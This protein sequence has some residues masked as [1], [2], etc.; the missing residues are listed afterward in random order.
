[1]NWEI[2]HMFFF[3]L[4]L[5]AYMIQNYSNKTFSLKFGGKLAPIQNEL[6]VIGAALVLLVAGYA[7]AMPSIA[8]LY[9][10]IYGVFY[11]L[12][13]FFL[14]LAV[15]DGSLG[16]S[17]IICNMG[18]IF[19]AVFG[20]LFYADPFG[21]FTVIGSICM[22]LAVILSAPPSDK[23][24]S[25][26]RAWFFFALLSACSNGTLG[27][28]K[29]HVT[30]TMPELHS[31]TFLFWSFLFASAVGMLIIAVGI[32]R[33]LPIKECTARFGTKLITGLGAGLGTALAN[34]FFFLA[35]A[36]NI[37]S[38]ILFPLNTGLLSTLLFL[39]SWLVFK[40]TKL[41]KR[42]LAALVICVLGAIFINIK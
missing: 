6:C 34:L 9:A 28:L 30:R 4:S 8:F 29:I 23:K 31:G 11:F 35:L 1:M 22:V 37:S 32:I 2:N 36:S 21:I 10:G 26:S 39:M 7:K 41:T 14:L 17:T 20:I 27:S 19:S 25:S 3:V 38:A 13:I 16:L 15:S 24:K 42:T 12:T 33:G 40:D 5:A 18:N